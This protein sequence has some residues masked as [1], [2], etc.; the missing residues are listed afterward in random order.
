LEP[1]IEWEAGTGNGLTNSRVLLLARQN[2]NA[3]VFCARFC[4]HFRNSTTQKIPVASAEN[5][6]NLTLIFPS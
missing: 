3:E 2:V 1:G 4:N 6:Q 5:R